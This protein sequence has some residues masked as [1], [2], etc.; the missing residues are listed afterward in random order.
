MN[1]G[2]SGGNLQQ[3]LHLAAAAPATLASTGPGTTAEDVQVQQ[4]GVAS[5]VVATTGCQPP[6]RSKEEC[7]CVCREERQYVGRRPQ[8]Q[9]TGSGGGSQQQQLQETGVLSGRRLCWRR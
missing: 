1:R 2:N 8:W 6:H 5:S 4:H 9:Q 7:S 3:H